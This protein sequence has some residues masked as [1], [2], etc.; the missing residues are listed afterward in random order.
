MILKWWFGIVIITVAL[1][2]FYQACVWFAKSSFGTADK[3][4]PLYSTVI[5]VHRLACY[6]NLTT[7]NSKSMVLS[8]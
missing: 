8:S 4:S 6:N 1:F 2:E 7:K 5:F 3:Q